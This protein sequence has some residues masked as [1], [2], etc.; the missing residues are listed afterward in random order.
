L[1]HE[2]GAW[3]EERPPISFI[4]TMINYTAIPHPYYT[5]DVLPVFRFVG[6]HHDG[7]FQL[8]VQLAEKVKHDFG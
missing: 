8:P 1:L 7:L 3:T 4:S 5:V 2:A 6:H